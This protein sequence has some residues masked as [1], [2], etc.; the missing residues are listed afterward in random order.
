[1]AV[2]ANQTNVSG[3]TIFLTSSETALNWI[4]SGAVSDE[5][6]CSDIVWLTDG[7]ATI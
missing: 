3:K 6:A 7:I 1:M 5:P 4:E 2:S